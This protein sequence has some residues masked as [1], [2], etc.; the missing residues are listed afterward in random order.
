MSDNNKPKENQKR[1]FDE[2]QYQMLVR[3][4][5]KKDITEWNEW[6]DA[7]QEAPILLEGAD[8]GGANLKGADLWKANLKGAELDKANLE[9]A[10]LWEANLEGADLIYANLKGADFSSAVLDG[11]T[12]LWDCTINEETDFT[13]TGLD[14]ARVEPRLKVTLEGIIRKNGINGMKKDRNGDIF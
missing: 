13:G 11:K 3:C 8:L 1:Q 7:H 6:H 12:L 9:G 4:S 14:S 5:E 10:K 2:K